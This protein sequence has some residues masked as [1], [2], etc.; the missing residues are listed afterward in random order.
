MTIN[1]IR[2]KLGFAPITP[3]KSFAHGISKVFNRR[4]QSDDSPVQNNVELPVSNPEQMRRAASE[5]VNV[6]APSLLV[7]PPS[8]VRK[9]QEQDLFDHPPPPTPPKDE[10]DLPLV[11]RPIRSSISTHEYTN[12][13]RGAALHPDTMDV[14][15]LD[16]DD[17]IDSL[18]STSPLPPPPSAKTPAQIQAA[19]ARSKW[20][21]EVAR[22][23]PLDPAERARRRIEAE[24]QRAVEEQQAILEEAERQARL[25]YERDQELRAFQDEEERRKAIL[26]MDLKR[27]A[28]ERLMQEQ[29]QREAEE[30]KQRAVEEKRR[31]D[32]ERR[33]LEARKVEERL[34]AERRKTEEEARRME[35]G[36]RRA[37]EERTMKMK[38]IQRQLGKM[39]GSSDVILTGWIS[40]QTNQ[41]IVWKRRW[42]VFTGKSVSFYKSP[43][44]RCPPILPAFIC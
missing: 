28:A 20:A 21:A 24:R 15:S 2:Y 37:Q 12:S 35:E 1:I 41:L 8:M 27:A 38:D 39:N 6:T 5:S 33:I 11:H 14:I 13:H 25:K 31:A 18:R 44:V 22:N 19:E 23:Q 26:Q 29:A 16:L 34:K 43:Q 36:R 40:A 7:P 3:V 32:K 30:E 9:L 17:D 42:F 10:K 4:S